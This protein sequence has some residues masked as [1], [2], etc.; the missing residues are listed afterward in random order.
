MDQ[1]SNKSNYWTSEFGQ[2]FCHNSGNFVRIHQK[3]RNLRICQ[4]FLNYSSKFWEIFIEIGAKFDEKCWKIAIFA[5]ISA[6]IWKSLAKFCEDFE[7]RAVQRCDN[8]VDLEK[9]CKMSIWTQKSA[10]IQLRTS[11]LK[12]DDLAEKSEQDSISNLLTKASTCPC[13]AL[14]YRTGNSDFSAKSS[15]FRRLVLRCIGTKFYK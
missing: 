8:L 6:K 7:F 12:F 14:R 11:L 5:E 15:N 10:L 1:G 13:T 2:K 3:S 9:R 4:P